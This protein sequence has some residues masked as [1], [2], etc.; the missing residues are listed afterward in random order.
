MNK[1]FDSLG[2][3]MNT[4]LTNLQRLEAERKDNQMRD[5]RVGAI[6]YDLQA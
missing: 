2:N 1:R 5:S 3:G 4:I 6:D